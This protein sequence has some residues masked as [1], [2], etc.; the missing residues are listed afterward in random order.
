MNIL[1][2]VV[3]IVLLLALYEGWRRGLILQLCSLVGIVVAIWLAARYGDVVGRWLGM[4]EAV[5]VAGGFAVVLVVTLVAVAVAGHLLRKI[6]RFAG[7]G[8]LD[9][10][11]GIVVAVIKYLLL[12]SVAFAALERLNADHALVERRTIESSHWYEPVRGLADRVFPFI[13]W[14]GEQIPAMEKEVLDE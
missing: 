6:F 7:F 4:D 12:L 9:I 11:L 8:L 3:Y 14:V 10:L 5:A 2:L 13:D 1:D